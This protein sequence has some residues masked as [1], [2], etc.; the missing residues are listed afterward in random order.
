[1]SNEGIELK[2]KVDVARVVA[3]LKELNM[4]MPESKKALKRALGA[5]ARIIQKQAKANLG[6]VTNGAS[7]STLKADGLKRFVRY[8]VY[9][10]ANGAWVHIQK[11]KG[12]N[13]SYMLKWF[14]EGTDE[15][16]NGRRKRKILWNRKL[17]KKRYTGYIRPSHFFSTAVKSKKNEAEDR[18]EELIIKYIKKVAE[19]RK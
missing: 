14:E 17:S 9:R 13:K 5:S 18:L 2:V 10:D 7:G 4:T 19:K 6:N 16:Y 15:R 3:L 11:S 8:K 1:M 12:K